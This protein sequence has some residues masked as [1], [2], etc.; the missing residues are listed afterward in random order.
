MLSTE[1]MK[2]QVIPLFLLPGGRISR[3]LFWKANLVLW[4]GLFS[5]IFCLMAAEQLLGFANDLSVKILLVALIVYGYAITVLTV[6]R[7]HDINWSSWLAVPFILTGIFWV[8][9]GLISSVKGKNTHGDNLIEYEENRLYVNRGTGLPPLAPP[10]DNPISK[11][12]LYI[13]MLL[14]LPSL[15]V[16]GIVMPEKSD[17]AVVSQEQSLPFVL[18]AS[19]KYQKVEAVDG[20]DAYYIVTRMNGVIEHY[21]LDGEL[22]WSNVGND[23][24]QSAVKINFVKQIYSDELKSEFDVVKQYASLELKHLI[25]QRDHISD[26][27]AGDMCDW[28]RNILSPGNGGLDIHLDEIKFSVL[29]S[30]LIRASFYNFN[31][32][33]QI[34]FDIQCE[35][36][37]CTISDIYDSN[38]YKKELQQIVKKGEC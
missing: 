3:G 2:Q 18:Q 8:I 7:L 15:V 24:D 20:M 37:V 35:E 36:S 28:V 4:L 34:D 21:S 10:F 25:S 12:I 11:I 29:K 19:E 16:A 23:E 6:K 27:N 30:G 14:P 31:E 32:K 13:M 1:L 26:K 5:L 38:S 17:T 22:L 9:V 33:H